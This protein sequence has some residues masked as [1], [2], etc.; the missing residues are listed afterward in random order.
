MNPTL[1]DF[2]IAIQ[3][4]SKGF[5]GDSVVKNHLPMQELQVRFL[6]QENHLEKKMATQPTPVFLPRKSH[7][8]RSL[9]GYSI[10]S[11]RTV[12]HDLVTKQQQKQVFNTLK[13]ILCFHNLW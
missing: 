1:L 2:T 4:F 5:P 13:N 10:W 9:R 7:E 3:V 8:Q 6:G 11:C 12:G